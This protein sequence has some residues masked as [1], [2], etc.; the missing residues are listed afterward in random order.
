M[1]VAKR[2]LSGSRDGIDCSED[3]QAVACSEELLARPAGEAPS[4][5]QIVKLHEGQLLTGRYM[6]LRQITG[7]WLAFDERLGRPVCIVALVAEGQ[8]PRSASG[9]KP[10]AVR[11]LST[12]SST[13]TRHSRSG[14]FPTWSVRNC[15]S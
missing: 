15:S 13:E 1:R 14:R 3:T 10:L 5:H 8:S 6:V 12:R 11:R 7:G 4:D 9:G 2:T